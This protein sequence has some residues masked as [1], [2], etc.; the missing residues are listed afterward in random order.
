MIKRGTNHYLRCAMTAGDNTLALERCEDT[1]FGGII[2][3][4]NYSSI[5][6]YSSGIYLAENITINGIIIANAYSQS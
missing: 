3:P 4:Y 6:Y 1:Y 5:I 2:G